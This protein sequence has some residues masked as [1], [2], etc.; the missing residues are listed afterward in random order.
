MFI[1]FLMTIKLFNC[2]YNEQTNLFYYFN[3]LNRQFS[4]SIKKIDHYKTLGIFPNAT[5]K[6]IKAAFFKLSKKYHPDASE[7][8]K[9][10]NSAELFQ[11]VIFF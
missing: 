3:A 7:K 1:E 6:E 8:D 2:L 10:E 11:N 4:S 5:P 9:I